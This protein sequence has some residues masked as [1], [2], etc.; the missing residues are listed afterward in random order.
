[1]SRKDRRFQEKLSHKIANENPLMEFSIGAEALQAFGPII[2]TDVGITEIYAKSLKEKNLMIPKPIRCRLLI[3]TGADHC[4]V[5]HEIAEKAGLKLINASSPI[6][7]VGVDT[8]GKIYMGRIW[9]IFQ[10]RIEKVMKHNV[11]VD[12]EIMSGGMTTKRIDG[13]IGRDVLRHFD[14]KYYGKFGKFT[15]QYIK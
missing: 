7:G 3:D 11:W 2:V 5:K 9:F 1:M 15:L 14:F 6:H 8:T 4:M 12:A 13:V 10:S